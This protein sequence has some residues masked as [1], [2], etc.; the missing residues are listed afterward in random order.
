MLRDDAPHSR[1]VALAPIGEEM[2]VFGYD[3]DGNALSFRIDRHGESS[4]ADLVPDLRGIVATEPFTHDAVLAWSTSFQPG[5][6]VDVLT[7]ADGDI[8]VRALDGLGERALVA[9]YL[10]CAGDLLL[11]THSGSSYAVDR[12]RDLEHLE[13]VVEFE[14]SVGITSFALWE[15]SLVFGADGGWI[16]RAAAR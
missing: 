10:L 16:L 14:S 15:D 7:T 6:L 5:K 1:F 8:A 13:R 11:L 12:T 2:L 3:E 9:T 4:R